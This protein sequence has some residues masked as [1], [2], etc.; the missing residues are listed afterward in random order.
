MTDVATQQYLL[1]RDADSGTVQLIAEGVT[2]W[3]SDSDPDVLEELGT[4][5]ITDDDLGDVLEYLVAGDYLT[6][7]E[8]DECAVDSPEDEG[9]DGED[10]DGD[11]DED[12]GEDEEELTP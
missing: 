10:E 4:D 7:A 9:G 3:S 8:A 2:L 1:V 12:E 11:E 6:E 5:V